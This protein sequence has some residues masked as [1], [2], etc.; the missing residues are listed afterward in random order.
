MQEHGPAMLAVDLGGTRLRAAVFDAAGTRRSHVVEQTPRD[1]PGALVRAMEVAAAEAGMRP[2]RAVVG[3]P[4]VVDLVAG[5]APHLPQLPGWHGRV[6]AASIGEALGMPVTLANDADLAALG[7][8][9]FGAGRGVDHLVYLTCST[10]VGAGVIVG[11]RLLHTRT[12]L[13]EV[14]HTIIDWHSGTTVEELGSGGALGRRAGMPAEEV[15]V[16][17]RAGDPHAAALFRD[18]AAAFAVG[19]VTMILCFMP[20]R[21]VIGGGMARSG[22]LLLEPVRKRVRSAPHLAFPP[23][24]IVTSEHGDDAGLLGAFALWRE[25]HAGAR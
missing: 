21:V 25:E 14:G 15:A 20:E 3:V 19:V 2:Q 13:A 4:G 23:E 9:R 22:D 12:S 11:G 24:A 8:H 7:E 16:R 5:A 10:G 17:A 1:D 18:T 6:T